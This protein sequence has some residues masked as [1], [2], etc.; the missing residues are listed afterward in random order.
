MDLT[1]TERRALGTFV[2]RARTIR[3]PARAAVDKSD[4]LR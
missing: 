2:E 3:K 4:G 1:R